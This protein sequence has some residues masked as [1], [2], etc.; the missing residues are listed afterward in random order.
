[1]QGLRLARHPICN[2]TRAGCGGTVLPT[3]RMVSCPR[4]AGPRSRNGRVSSFRATRSSPGTTERPTGE[5]CRDAFGVLLADGRSAEGRGIFFVASVSDT[6]PTVE[7]LAERW[8][9]SVF[10]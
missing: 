3:I 1:M 4:T 6:L 5:G 2:G 9:K 7:G 8:G 10:R